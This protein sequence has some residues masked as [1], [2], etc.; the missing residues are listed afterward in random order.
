MGLDTA[1][2]HAIG[3]SVGAGGDFAGRDKT[4]H[5]HNAS[6]HVALPLTERERDDW[7]IA[8]IGA[9]TTGL[10]QVH[11]KLEK[12]DQI[13]DA[14]TGNRLY[15]RLGLVADVHKLWSWIVGIVLTLV[16]LVAFGIAQWYM[17]W[18]IWVSL[19]G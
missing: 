8:Q 11:S 7:V 9:I 18:Q 15:G 2:G 17:L 14:L 12:L 13:D 6:V 16:V 4:D 10:A 3:G 5:S 1:G 19:Y